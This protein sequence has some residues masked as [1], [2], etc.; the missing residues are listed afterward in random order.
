M[1]ATG[2]NF[3]IENC[4]WGRDSPIGCHKNDDGSACPSTTWVRRMHAIGHSL[5]FQGDHI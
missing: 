2:K 4:H 1:K 5:E 3:S